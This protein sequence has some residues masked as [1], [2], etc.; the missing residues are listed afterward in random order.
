[1]VLFFDGEGN[2]R[3]GSNAELGA[4]W[5]TLQQQ[6]QDQWF[7]RHH[8][9]ALWHPAGLLT[10]V[11]DKATL[12]S[13]TR[14]GLPA[15]SAP[16]SVPCFHLASAAPRT[17]ASAHGVAINREGKYSCPVKAGAVFFFQ[18][19][20]EALRLPAAEGPPAPM[21]PSV[22][23]GPRPAAEATAAPSPL[24]HLATNQLEAARAAIEGLAGGPGCR[25]LQDVEELHTVLQL[26]A[27]GALP[28]IVQVVEGE[29]GVVVEFAPQSPAERAM[30]SA[31]LDAM[32]KPGAA[33]SDRAAEQALGRVTRDVSPTVW[34]RF[35]SHAEHVAWRS[36]DHHA[37]LSAKLS[38]LPELRRAAAPGIPTEQLYVLE[39]NGEGRQRIT[40]NSQQTQSS[41][42]LLLHRSLS[43]M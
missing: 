27:R 30:D 10:T 18:L 15:A 5:T 37:R 7:F 26:A 31:S 19:P 25:A 3:P 29:A 43:L 22:A 4:A 2:R 8:R 13:F 9:S 28:P 23:Q 34:F 21:P 1:M 32:F 38:L 6:L 41:S 39:P 36:M 42:S 40:S 16:S 20:R 11:L 35:R 14:M 24:S 17:L 12:T 33:G